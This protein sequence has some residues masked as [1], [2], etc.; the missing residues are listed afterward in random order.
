LSVTSEWSQ[1]SGLT[2]F[3]L[4]P[5][6]GRVVPAKAVAAVLVTVPATAVAFAFGAVGNVIGTALADIPA[7]WDQSLVEV[8]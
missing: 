2:T 8:G 5:H 3:T 7:V 6:R 1:S 4:V